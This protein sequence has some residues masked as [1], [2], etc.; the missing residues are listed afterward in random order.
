MKAD[1][2]ILVVSSGS[3]LG[4]QVLSL[5]IHLFPSAPCPPA[6]LRVV[7]RTVVKDTQILRAS[8][9][10][11]SCPDSE[12]LLGLK[13]NIQDNSQALFDLASYWTSRTFFEIPLP[14]GS[15][16][17]A[18]IRARNSA[19]SSVESAAVT[20][21]T[22]AQCSIILALASYLLKWEMKML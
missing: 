8:W 15:S 14:C 11:V 16:Y 2:N 6:G 13:G 12:Y 18:T 5:V 10:T 17:S 20:G 7:P 4:K 21:T 19:A 3:P 9:S 22:G 1:T